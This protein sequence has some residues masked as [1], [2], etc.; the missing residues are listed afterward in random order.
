MTRRERRYLSTGLDFS[1]EADYRQWRKSRGLPPS[2]RVITRDAYN[3]PQAL[4]RKV[5]A[6]PVNPDFFTIIEDY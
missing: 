3:G 4:R 2:A 6:E 5:G 1:T